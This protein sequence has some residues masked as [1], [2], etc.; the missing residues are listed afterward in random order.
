MVRAYVAILIGEGAAEAVVEAIRDLSGVSEVHIVA[1]DFDAIAEV[2][3]ETVRDLQREVTNGIHE[4][5][6]V[7]TTRT[8]VQLD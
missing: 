2:E 8:Y 7:G 3:A 5:A 6:D 1:G 4:L